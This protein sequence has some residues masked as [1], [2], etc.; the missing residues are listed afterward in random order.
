MDATEAPGR[1]MDIV[2]FRGENVVMAKDQPE[3]RPMPAYREY[4][5]EGRLTCCWSLSLR[6]RL[7]VLFTGRIWQSVLTF[8]QQLQ[9]QLLEV[10]RPAQIPDTPE[11]E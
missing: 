1:L 9:P 3:Y 6:E 11:L 4:T 5:R 7:R 2:H 10:D 8:N